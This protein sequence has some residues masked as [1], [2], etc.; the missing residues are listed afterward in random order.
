MMAVPERLEDG[1]GEPNRREVL[2][3]LLP[4]VVVYPVD[5]LLLQQLRQLAVQLVRR[6]LRS[7][8]QQA[9]SSRYGAVMERL[10][11]LA[12]GGGRRAAGGGEREGARTRSWPNGFSTMTR[13]QPTV[14]MPELL[15]E[16][17][18]GANTEGGMAR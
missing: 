8:R 12:A 5:L 2:H 7:R 3:H 1:V 13:V 4:E 15:I 16:R 9:V 14:A 11:L 10:R 17:A 18:A 6:R